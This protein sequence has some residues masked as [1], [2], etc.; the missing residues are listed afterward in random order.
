MK[1]CHSR[2]DRIWMNTRSEQIRNGSQ[3]LFVQSGIQSIRNGLDPFHFVIIVAVV[4]VVVVAAAVVV[5]AVV[6]VVVVSSS[7][8]G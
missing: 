7:F 8:S 2:H 6:A 5:V 4:V 3:G 1:A